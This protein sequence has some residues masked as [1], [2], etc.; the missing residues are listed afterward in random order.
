MAHPPQNQMPWQPA[1]TVTLLSPP[2]PG[3]AEVTILLALRDGA[4]YLTPQLDSIAAQT[5]AHWRLIVSDDGSTD[6]SI[7]TLLN[8]TSQ[9]APRTVRLIFGP[10]RGFAM[11]FLAL[12]AEAGS[13]APFVAFSDQDDVWFPEKLERALAALSAVPSGT[14]A[15][16]T[17]RR[18]ICDER[19]GSL[20]AS[21][22]CDRAPGFR[23]ALV[24]NIA[25]GNTIVINRAA[26]RLLQAASRRITWL[27]AHDWWAYLMITGAGGRVIHD[28]APGLFYRQHACN[29]IGARHGIAAWPGLMRFGLT[30][31]LRRL[32]DTN[33]EAL[34]LAAPYLTP[35]N[36]ALVERFAAARRAPRR[37]RLKT[38]RALGLYR[39]GRA[40]TFGLWLTAALGLL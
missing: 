38:L 18:L 15:L 3:P 19:L 7:A 28:P 25:P 9:Q 34:E 4:A 30:G 13:N 40:G 12:L 23:N 1:E 16:Y 27:Y 39:Q 24:Q 36:R 26:L 33:I 32:Q 21:A 31:E 8:W 2:P 14:P 10:R 29:A 5:H 6:E 37:Q 35:E 11:N 20:R 17:S 22:R